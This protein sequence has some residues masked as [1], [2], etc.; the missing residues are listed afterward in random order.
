[1]SKCGLRLYQGDDDFEDKTRWVNKAKTAYSY[2]NDDDGDEDDEEDFIFI[3][4]YL[5]FKSDSV[6]EDYFEWIQEYLKER[7]DE[8]FD[9]EVD[10]EYAWKFTVDFVE[11]KYHEKIYG[12]WVQ[13]EEVVIG[14]LT[15]E[16]QIDACRSVVDEIIAEL[17]YGEDD[18]DLDEYLEEAKKQ[19]RSEAVA[20]ATTTTKPN[21]TTTAT[22]ETELITEPEEPSETTERTTTTT[23]YVE[24]TD[25][26]ELYNSI[27][28][29]EG[30]S[31]TWYDG[32]S[33]EMVLRI[34]AD[35][36]DS[37]GN[38]IHFFYFEYVDKRTAE[39]VFNHDY[40]SMMEDEY[41]IYDFQKAEDAKA[42]FDSYTGYLKD[43]ATSYQVEADWGYV[44]YQSGDYCYGIYHSDNG[45][46]TVV[47]LDANADCVDKVSG[48]FEGLCG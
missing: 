29:S 30:F 23:E 9:F 33:D 43:Y 31:V 3:V 4:E 19:I 28:E 40:E 34:I 24:L 44:A 2:Y 17:G 16:A 42:Y 32:W 37:D 6:A 20:T 38:N 26:A 15:Y 48:F 22:F 35:K 8:D 46:I 25:A 1:M 47:S 45:V 5:E 18:G 14:V 10:F 41:T 11:E 7:S 21:P 27:M 39:D 13:V 12:I 36:W